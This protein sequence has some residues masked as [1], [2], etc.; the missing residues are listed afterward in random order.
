MRV[1]E[2]YWNVNHTGELPNY[3]KGVAKIQKISEENGT[4]FYNKSKS[5]Y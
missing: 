5:S 4:E 3:Q 1:S 2:N